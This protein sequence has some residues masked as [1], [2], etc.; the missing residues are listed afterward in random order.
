LSALS[1]TSLTNFAT[2]QITQDIG[3]DNINTNGTSDFF[4]DYDLDENDDDDDVFIS[5]S[6]IQRAAVE[7]A[8]S[9]LSPLLLNN[10]DNHNNDT[11]NDLCTPTRFQDDQIGGIEINDNVFDSPERKMSTDFILKNNKQHH[12]RFVSRVD[13]SLSRIND[14]N[15][16]FDDNNTPRVQI[17]KNDNQV[18]S[19]QCPDLSPIGLK[20]EIRN[21]IKK[22]SP[23]LTPKFTKNDRETE[24]NSGILFKKSSISIYSLIYHF[25]RNVISRK[26]KH[27]CL[28][29]M[30][31]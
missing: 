15:K 10:S 30:L 19:I 16:C 31:N 27:K 12:K 17:K 29:F 24:N 9:Q 6:K 25:K 18:S 22:K 26:F 20:Q 21:T 4:N 23:F 1:R 5:S 13:G 8:L 11:D 2:N 14:N 28:L 3:D 7:M